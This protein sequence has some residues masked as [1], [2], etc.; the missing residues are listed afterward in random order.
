SATSTQILDKEG[1]CLRINPKLSEL[2]GV[3]P[4]HIENHTY[5]IFKDEE[6]QRQG[7]DKILGKVF[8]ENQTAYWE[9]HFDIGIAADSQNIQVNEKK[10]VWYSNKAYPIVNNLGELMYVIIQHEDISERKNGEKALRESEQLFRST[11]ENATAGVCL[12]G[13]DGKFIK[14]NSTLCNM[15]GYTAGE[16]NYLKFNDIT[17]PPDKE[18]GLSFLKDLISGQIEHASFEK[19]YIRKDGQII[20]GYLSITVVR[21]SSLRPAYFI[22][23]I[24]DISERTKAKE[25][26]KESEEQFRTLF[27]NAVLGIYRT[28]PDGTI[29][30]VNQALCKMLGYS[31]TEELMKRNLEEEGFQPNYSRSSFKDKFQDDTNY[32]CLESTWNKADGS[33]I[34]VREN[35]KAVRDHSGKVLYY[36]GTVEDITA[37]KAAEEALVKSEQQY[38]LLFEN[39]PLPMWIYDLDSLRFLE[40]NKVAVEYYGYSRQEFLSM[41]LMDIRPQSEIEPLLENVALTTDNYSKTNSWRHLKKNGEIIFVEITSHTIEYEGKRA[42]LVLSNDITESKKAQEDLIRAKKDAEKSDQL[43]SEFLAQMSHEIRSPISTML[44][45]ISLIKEEVA[46]PLNEEMIFCFNAIDSS[47][48]RLI[49]TI[50]LILNMSQI[51]TGYLEC[52]YQ[53]LNL[54]T[55]VLN[56]TINEYSTSAAIKGLSLTFFNE[57]GTPTINADPYTVIQIFSN[58]I[59]NAI[60]YTKTGVI[61]VRIYRNHEDAISVD[62]S[63]TGIGISEQYIDHIFTPFS[64]EEQGYTRKFEG[65]GLGLALV[66]KYCELNNATI[67]VKSQKGNGSIF[68]VTFHR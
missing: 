62:V 25:L 3:K 63:D 29:I 60:K 37:S 12:T 38:R 35:T 5:N 34:F 24:Q 14:V 23:H 66:K 67:S 22:T 54:E 2:F 43:K 53:I 47:S 19:R 44:N 48:R 4:E 27:E 15:F 56:N 17:Y 61:N 49:R 6:I 57:Y 7:I 40:V 32:L 68:T 10:K 13:T 50:D 8:N 30:K 21:E 59:N 18:I 42:R 16:L 20:W 26:L 28:S 64:Q 65:N 39:N 55:D 52:N 9:V 31:S 45:F 1:W 11:F 36:D 51:Q 41:T 46:R 33:V 58:L